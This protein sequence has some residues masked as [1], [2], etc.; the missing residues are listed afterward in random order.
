MSTHKICF[1]GEI[2]KIICGYSRLSVAMQKC[3]LEPLYKNYRM[4]SN[5]KRFKC[6]A[7]KCY[8]RTKMNRLY[9]KMTI[10][11]HFSILSFHFFLH[12]KQK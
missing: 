12:S 3:S 10:Y 11:G 9:R 2:R 5:T 8:I 6:G 1:R 7:L 4:V